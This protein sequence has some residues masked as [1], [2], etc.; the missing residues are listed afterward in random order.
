MDYLVIMAP[1]SWLEILTRT[2]LRWLDNWVKASPKLQL[3]WVVLGL[4]WSVPIVSGPCRKS[5]KPPT[6]SL[7]RGAKGWPVWSNPTDELL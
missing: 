3:L 6:E 4:Q 7:M 5:G 2:K 1:V